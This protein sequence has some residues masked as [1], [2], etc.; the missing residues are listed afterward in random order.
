MVSGAGGG[1]V[2]VLLLAYAVIR[3]D[4]A[5]RLAQVAGKLTD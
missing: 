4:V 5:E 3:L 2:S 1:D